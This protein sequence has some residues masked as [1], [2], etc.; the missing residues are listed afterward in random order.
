[1]TAA[2]P[3]AEPIGAFKLAGILIRFKLRSFRNG[4]RG[5]TR[6][7]SPLF[8]TAVVLAMGLAYSVLFTQA[9]AIIARNTDIAGQI[10]ALALILGTSTL[11][12]LAAR[13]ASNEA[14]R[15]GSPMR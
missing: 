1:M 3:D 6:R 9:F 8:V 12:S 5:R 15:A 4:F 7:R 11:G 2:A 13:A 10:A 14:V